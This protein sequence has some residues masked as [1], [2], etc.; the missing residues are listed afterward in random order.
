MRLEQESRRVCLVLLFI[1]HLSTCLPAV[2]IMPMGFVPL[3]WSRRSSQSPGRRGRLTV[4]ENTRNKTVRLRAAQIRDTDLKSEKEGSNLPVGIKDPAAGPQ[5]CQGWMWKSERVAKAPQQVLG[6]QAVL[7]QRLHLL[8]RGALHRA[9]PA[10]VCQLPS[11]PALPRS[12]VTFWTLW[13]SCA[14]MYFLI[15][16]PWDESLLSLHFRLCS[17]L[18]F[19]SVTLPKCWCIT[20]LSQEQ[21]SKIIACDGVFT[22]C[23][24]QCL[25]QIFKLARETS[26]NHR[27][28]LIFECVVGLSVNCPS[29]LT[30]K[31]PLPACPI[32]QFGGIAIMS[33]L[34][35]EL[36]CE[37][38]RKKSQLPQN[39]TPHTH[40][41]QS[42]L[43][44]P[45]D[46]Q[47]WSWGSDLGVGLV[48]LLLVPVH[49]LMLSWKLG[50]L[51]L[52]S[53]SS[54]VSSSALQSQAE[55]I[56]PGKR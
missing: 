41:T 16:F 49:P 33:I 32:P 45:I 12:A 55:L 51:W 29:C 44:A 46:T 30:L 38:L 31:V 35:Y 11:H 15:I 4:S 10:F 5:Q 9:V 47:G 25:A 24:C 21:I 39:K 27:K 42:C 19:C 6:R 2:M 36:I 18:F 28:A 52:S 1:C 50:S 14:Q 54:S 20:E 37:R 23:N 3:S 17:K 22:S 26:L 40:Y 8:R 7:L 13:C 43:V 48:G 56:I 34:E 53:S